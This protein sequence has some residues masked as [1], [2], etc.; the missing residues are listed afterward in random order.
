MSRKN[1]A[2][3]YQQITSPAPVLTHQSG[4]TAIDWSV[5][6]HGHIALFRKPVSISRQ[7]SVQPQVS[8]QYTPNLCSRACL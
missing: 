6:R 2:T 7:L 3:L 1:R 4:A 5:Y 8:D